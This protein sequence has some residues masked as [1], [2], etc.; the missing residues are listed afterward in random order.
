MKLADLR[1]ENRN[2]QYSQILEH[3]RLKLIDA[4]ENPAKVRGKVLCFIGNYA[5]FATQGLV[6][7]KFIYNFAEKKWI[8]S[9]KDM[10]DDFEEFYNKHF[11]NYEMSSEF[12][13]MFEQEGYLL[14]I[15]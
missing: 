7:R 8:I 6:I 9:D 4:I 3:E 10:S 15:D 12:R 2:E 11:E 13:M 14:D 1:H 5:G